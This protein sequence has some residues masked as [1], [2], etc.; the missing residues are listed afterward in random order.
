[1]SFRISGLFLLALLLAGCAFG[2]RQGPLDYPTPAEAAARG[3]QF[4]GQIVEWGGVI[5]G[6]ENQAGRSW[7]EILAYPLNEEGAPLLDLPPLGRF[8]AF[9]HSYIETA[10]FAPGRRATVQGPL[11]GT[12]KGKVGATDY[13]FP[14]L[15]AQAL[16][17]WRED[18]RFSS[19]P[20]VRFGI[21]IGIGGHW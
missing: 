20:D 17:L 14:L 9:R 10:D 8:R 2:P 7:L 15:E 13:D 12:E 19:R 11:R 6:G 3:G 18:R 1:M 16:R 4:D 21:G 5:T